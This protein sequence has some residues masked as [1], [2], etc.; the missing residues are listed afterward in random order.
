MNDWIASF[1]QEQ[2]LPA[3][4]RRTI[5]GAL[6]PLAGSVAAHARLADQTLVVGLC[7]A[8]GSGKTTAAAVLAGLLAVEGLPAIAL[9]IDDFYLPRAER[10]VLA[11]RVHPLLIT[12]GVPGTHDVELAQATIN[13]LAGA[14]TTWI[15]V[16]D[17]ATDDRLPRIAWREVAERPRVVILEGWCVGARPQ[18]AGDLAVPVN[19]L[20]R[21]EDAGGIWRGYVNAALHGPYR[22][23]FARLSVLVLLA[24]PSF[25]VVREWRGEQERK[26]R[27]RTVREGGDTSRLMGEAQLARFISHY[28]RVTRHILAEMP[29]RADHLIALDRQRNAQLLR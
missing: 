21:E 10:V 20:E 29:A 9:S 19:T 15:P 28:E 23:L 25:D 6:R 12:R 1:L 17:K 18:S 13:S 2:G 24:A 26:L 7:G 8:Q 16:F 14:Q 27:A 3:D 5:D 11:R 22:E 4:Y